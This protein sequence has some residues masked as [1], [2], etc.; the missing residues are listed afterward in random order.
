MSDFSFWTKT[1]SKFVKNNTTWKQLK[2]L[3]KE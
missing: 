2:L 3:L 1:Y